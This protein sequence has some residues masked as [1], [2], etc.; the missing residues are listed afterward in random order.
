MELLPAPQA[1][2]WPRPTSHAPPRSA[3]GGRPRRGWLALPGLVALRAARGRW[4][5]GLREIAADYDA[6]LLDLWGARGVELECRWGVVHNG[7]VAFPW[8]RECLRELQKL[9][10]GP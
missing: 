6:F 8:A 7:T 3:L 9:R 1:R 5:G 2:P 4:I 10:Q